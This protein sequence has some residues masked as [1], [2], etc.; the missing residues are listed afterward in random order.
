MHS[1]RIKE[2][3]LFDKAIVIEE[4]KELIYVTATELLFLHEIMKT[5]PIAYSNALMLIEKVNENGLAIERK[6]K[7]ARIEDRR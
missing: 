5:E 1:Q 3:T 4:I 6:L 7:I 2:E